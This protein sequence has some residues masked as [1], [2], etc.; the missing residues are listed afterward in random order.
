MKLTTF[1]SMGGAGASAGLL[2]A[3]INPVVWWIPL[4]ACGAAMLLV[5]ILVKKYP[6]IDK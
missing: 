5:F 1:A 6:N 2:A 3:T 4:L